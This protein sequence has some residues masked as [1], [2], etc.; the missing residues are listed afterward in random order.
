MAGVAK[1]AVVALAFI[2]TANECNATHNSECPACPVCPVCAPCP[3]KTQQNALYTLWKQNRAM[4]KYYTTDEVGL[5][6]SREERQKLT[7]DG[8]TLTELYMKD[9]KK[10]V[11]GSNSWIFSSSPETRNS[12][13]V[14]V[15][16]ADSHVTFRRQLLYKNEAFSCAVVKEQYILSYKEFR[17][18]DEYC[19]FSS[20][21]PSS[22]GHTILVDGFL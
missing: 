9:G 12:M 11:L 8:V 22:Q 20:D 6:C 15:E 19:C 18:T 21:V 16:G 2:V 1:I 3:G 13:S 14:V 10:T 5:P 7:E 4:W 17:K